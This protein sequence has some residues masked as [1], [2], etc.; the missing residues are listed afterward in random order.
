MLANPLV[1]EFGVILLTVLV[2]L[3]VALWKQVSQKTRDLE[4]RVDVHRKDIDTLRAQF[5]EYL[6][7]K[8]LQVPPEEKDKKV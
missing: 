7:K 3:L 2:G 8:A 6:I 4:V 1:V 5:T